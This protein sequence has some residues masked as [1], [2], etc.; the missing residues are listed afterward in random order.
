MNKKILYGI[1]F[2]SIFL[3]S[4]AASIRPVQGYTW[5]VPKAA[6]GVT[7][8]GEV[9]AFDKK[10]FKSHLGEETDVEWFAD[11]DSDDVGA[12][13]KSTYK[14]METDEKLI[15]FEEKYVYEAAGFDEAYPLIQGGMWATAIYGASTSV[16]P[17]TYIIN[18][19]SWG[20]IQ[21]LLYVYG[22]SDVTDALAMA[23]QANATELLALMSVMNYANAMDIYGDKYDGSILTRD[24][25]DYEKDAFK[26]KPD[27]KD[28]EVP[29]L[30]DPRD[31]Y[32]SW[33]NVQALGAYITGTIDTILASLDAW[34]M[35]ASANLT[36]RAVVDGVIKASLANPTLNATVQYLGSS[37]PYG[38]IY[39]TGSYVLNY[40][41]LGQIR[42]EVIALI[43]DKF[44]Y[45]WQLLWAGLPT[46]VPQGD[47][48]ARMLKDFRAEDHFDGDHLYGISGL[49]YGQDILTSSGTPGQDGD[50]SGIPYGATIVSPIVGAIPLPGETI[51][52]YVYPKVTLTESTITI[53]VEYMN[54]Q[55]DPSDL[56]IFGG[57]N[58]D[59][60]KDFEVV[61][62]YG[63]TGAQGTITIQD[64][65][66]I[67]AQWG[68]V[69]QIPGF[70]VSILLGVSVLSII[71]LIYVVMKKRKM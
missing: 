8:E 48:L 22:Y 66:D 30:A 29:F 23:N 59:E 53:K 65:D 36:V 50:V 62:P 10:A 25:W 32:H 49:S 19:T 54:G 11:G 61:F 14:E 63:D 26:E 43:P 24:K 27:V 69:E 31:W 56:S 4:T 60:L 2:V 68:G 42:Q 12:K 45:L 51:Y 37:D 52:M 64:G 9:K 35:A 38:H 55:I 44:N 71:G 58:E 13:S 1:F 20:T 17:I 18:G 57:D 6:I 47:F 5:G 34:Y 40:F 46:Y 39:L 21:K 3:L 15:A 33:E 16:P 67:I 41:V 70:E 28:D 7:S